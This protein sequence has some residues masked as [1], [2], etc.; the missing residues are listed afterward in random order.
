MR[1]L[2]DEQTSHDAMLRRKIAALFASPLA[3]VG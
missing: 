2:E 1:L 3:Q